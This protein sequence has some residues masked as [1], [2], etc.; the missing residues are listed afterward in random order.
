[1]EETDNIDYKALYGKVSDELTQAR[2][3]ILDLKRTQGFNLT[4][5]AVNSWAT[6]NYTLI[7]LGV[8]LGT[9]IV[10]MFRMFVDIIHS[11]EGDNGSRLS[12]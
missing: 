7:I 12:E 6:R 1:M 11:K 10:S 8:M 4:F 3:K 2:I 5:E 9:F